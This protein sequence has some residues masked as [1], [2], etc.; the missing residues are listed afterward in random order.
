MVPAGADA[1]V[2]E[3]SALAGTAVPV[4][5]SPHTAVRAVT[6][7]DGERRPWR[8]YAVTESACAVPHDSPPKVE[9]RT[10]VFVSDPASRLTA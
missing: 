7:A 10:L 9:E 4:H 1:T 3:R 6:V 8:S 2:W 5:G